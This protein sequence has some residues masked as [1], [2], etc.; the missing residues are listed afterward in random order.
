MSTN[1]QPRQPSG[2]PVGGQFAG[3][4]NPEPTDVV[5]DL[6]EE[7][8]PQE[9]AYDLNAAS[10][11]LIDT[12]K[13]QAAASGS[14][15]V[16]RGNAG[17]GGTIA[18]RPHCQLAGLERAVRED[19]SISF[20]PSALRDHWS[21]LDNT[22]TSMAG[23]TDEDLIQIADAALDDD[24]IWSAFDEV[25]AN[26]RDRLGIEHSSLGIR[27]GR[28][29]LDAIDQAI[30]NLGYN[31]SVFTAYTTGPDGELSGIV[32]QSGKRTAV[33]SSGVNW[34]AGFAVT[35]DSPGTSSDIPDERDVPD[36]GNTLDDLARL[37]AKHVGEPPHKRMS[38]IT[39]SAPTPTTTDASFQ[40]VME[41][42]GV[43]SWTAIAAEIG[44]PAAEELFNR[45]G[46]SLGRAMAMR[47]EERQEDS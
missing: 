20:S 17:A 32:V 10:F 19:R 45:S 23:V 7:T 24:Y 31:D 35:V 44:K 41:S 13:K 2:S 9:P 42:E 38:A 43:W 3:K 5:L 21:H 15:P 6:P 4:A 47:Q 18:H 37:L 16:C 27:V 29:D 46:G 26:A 40:A 36:T 30:R 8:D 1:T 22:S 28:G 12:L 25:L 34:G 11:A 39:E 14:C 33:V